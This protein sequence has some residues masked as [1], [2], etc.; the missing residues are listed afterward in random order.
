MTESEQQ[1]LF[2]KLVGKLI[3]YAYNQ[4]YELTFGE[5]WRS[6]QEAARDAAVGAGIANSLHTERLAVDLNLWKDGKYTALAIDYKPLGDYWKQL[7]PLCAWG[8]DF[9][10]VDA[11]HFSMAFGGRK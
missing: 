7:N 9:K 11:D 1:R 5:A 4:G 6:P 3:D 8:G 10:T 2:V